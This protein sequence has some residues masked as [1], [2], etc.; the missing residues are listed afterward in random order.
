VSEGKRTSISS[1]IALTPLTRR[2]A[3]S[4]AAF[5]GVIRHKA[6]QGD[7]AFIRRGADMGSVDTRFGI[8][9]HQEHL[10]EAV[11]R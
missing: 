3:R 1:A 7:D 4:A 8:R 11:N 2:A 10:D 9:A 6:G 5:L